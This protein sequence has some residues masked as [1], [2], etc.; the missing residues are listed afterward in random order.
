LKRWN[1]WGSDDIDY[2]APASALAYLKGKFGDTISISYF[3]ACIS[4]NGNS[5]IDMVS[6]IYVVLMN[7][8]VLFQ[9]T[10]EMPSESR[11]SPP[12]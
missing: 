11:Y 8:A 9:G 12:P 4:R 1:G 5:E 3:V 6:L 2:P 7:S 10:I